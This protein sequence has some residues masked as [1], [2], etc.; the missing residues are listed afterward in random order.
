MHYR[1]TSEFK[2]G[3][4]KLTFEKLKKELIFRFLFCLPKSVEQSANRKEYDIVINDYARAKN[5]FG[6]TEVP[7]RYNDYFSFFKQFFQLT[8]FQ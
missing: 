3:K 2:S 6:K 5:L 7:V 8:Y 4:I 1:G